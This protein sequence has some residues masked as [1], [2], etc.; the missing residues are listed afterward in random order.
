MRDASALKHSLA[1][2]E[3]DGMIVDKE[4]FRHGALRMYGLRVRR[5]WTCSIVK[6]NRRVEPT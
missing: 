3:H 4:G 2:I 5:P 6:L 1:G